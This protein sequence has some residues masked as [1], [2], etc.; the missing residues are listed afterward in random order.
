M[1]DVRMR[2]T[3]QGKSR[4]VT[5]SRGTRVT[6]ALLVAAVLPLVATTSRPDPAEAQIPG[7]EPHIFDANSDGLIT[8]RRPANVG[9]LGVSNGVVRVEDTREATAGHDYGFVT[10]P[11]PNTM[12]KVVKLADWPDTDGIHSGEI[13]DT[14]VGFL[15]NYTSPDLVVLRGASGRWADRG[16]DPGRMML[17]WYGQQRDGFRDTWGF[18]MNPNLFEGFEDSEKP[19]GIE[20]VNNVDGSRYLMLATDRAL[21]TMT[22]TMQDGAP[23]F[24]RL[25][26]KRYSSTQRI[27]GIHHNPQWAASPAEQYS[28]PENQQ[29][30]VG[31]LFGDSQYRRIGVELLHVGVDSGFHLFTDWIGTVNETLDAAALTGGDLRFS[32]SHEPDPNPH[33]DPWVPPDEYQELRVDV[34]LTT[35]ES[36]TRSTRQFSGRVSKEFG[37][38]LGVDHLGLQ[39]VTSSCASPATGFDAAYFRASTTRQA[40]FT[41]ERGTALEAHVMCASPGAGGSVI[42][43]GYEQRG[44]WWNGNRSIPQQVIDPGSSGVA[45]Q[46]Q[47]SLSF[48][49]LEQLRFQLRQVN[50]SQIADMSPANLRAALLSDASFMRNTDNWRSTYRCSAPPNTGDG[51]FTHLFG[52]NVQA[53]V[54]V[55]TAATGDPLGAR[56]A[57]TS[58][59]L[60]T[61]SLQVP[62]PQGNVFDATTWRSDEEEVRTNLPVAG[63]EPLGMSPGVFLTRLPSVDVVEQVRLTGNSATCARFPRKPDGSLGDRLGPDPCI[64]TPAFGGP[65]PVAVMAAPPF[66]AGSGQES[67]LLPEFANGA[68]AT[69][70]TSKF[71]ST[72]VGAELEVSVGAAAKIPNVLEVEVETSVGVGYERETE[73]STSQ[74]LT[75]SKITGYGGSLEDDTVVTHKVRYLEYSGEVVEDSLGLHTGEATVIRVPI[76]NTVT[77]QT[78]RDLLAD[79]DAAS[80]WGGEGPF[81]QGL[82]ELQSHVPGLPGTYLGNRSGDPDRDLGDYCLGDLDPQQ[83]FR[84]VRKGAPAAA[85]PFV[86]AK[87]SVDDLPQIL[88]G[89]WGAVQA[90][91]HV[92]TQRSNIEFGSEE[93]ESFLE[94][95]TISASASWS[96]KVTAGG[97]SLGLRATLSAAG[98]WGNSYS[99]SLGTDTTFSG[100][101]GSIPDPR[102][103]AEQ[104]EWRMFVC[105]KEIAPGV[106][107]WVQGYQVRNYGG[108]YT[109]RGATDPQELGP[110]TAQSPRQSQSVDTTPEFAWSQPVGT[111][112]DYEVEVEAVGRFDPRTFTA[113][114]V[115]AAGAP[116]AGWPAVSTREAGTSFTVPD[117][118]ALLPDQLYRWRVVSNNFFHRSEESSWEYFTTDGSGGSTPTTAT[119][120]GTV[121][122]AG[123]PVAG[124]Q[125]RVF[126]SGG[127]SPLRYVATD[128]AGNWTVPGLPPGT[129]EVMAAPPSWRH[130]RRWLGSN[131][132]RVDALALPVGSGEIRSGLLI[133]LRARNQG[134]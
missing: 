1:S 79:P 75:L 20:I 91:N 45:I 56:N 100:A 103:A 48:P 77:S 86:S 92:T 60:V 110:V 22:W 81:A 16:T 61:R 37:R 21:Y 111:V 33:P 47:V 129:Y 95:N 58:L 99:S 127:D 27:L 15:T 84:E 3:A 23:S 2:A 59:R 18:A 117:G 62:P 76:G 132:G 72:A 70:E 28:L 83:G 134:A 96:A 51:N 88:T 46:P 128:A 10:Q 31:V 41:G 13:V 93:A 4:S 123:E 40:P 44:E 122:T 43:G 87:R 17:L 69:Q 82:K 24:T 55:P 80:W 50:P 11:D 125:V 109:E 108:I 53:T 119:L 74:A 94:S 67:Q 64:P 5:A 90:G 120:S 42:V 12:Q 8:N 106:P 130:L 73:S 52:G 26:T 124:A 107:V 36:G 14:A 54:S 19:V 34:N 29:S 101:V 116:L 98:S 57:A 7:P 63:D 115:D 32:I 38:P 118:E 112:K 30:L 113:P 133:N 126:S 25:H 6:V 97:A 114:A 68:S 102:L 39:Q 131:G 104:F 89:E 121:T 65:V 105:K 35:S 66:V 71:T 85:N 78:V 9:F 49:C